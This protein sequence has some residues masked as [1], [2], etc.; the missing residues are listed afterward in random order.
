MTY[1]VLARKW[2][3]QFFSDLIGQEAVSRTLENAIKLGKVPHAILFTGTRGVG[4]T[5]SARILAKALNC[6]KGP[7]ITPCNECSNCTEISAG[8]NVDVLEIDGASNTSVD[9]VRELKETV[10][11]APSKSRHKIYIID[12][13]HMLST[14][15]FNALLKTLEEP[16]PGV[17]FIFA[18]TEPQKIPETIHSRCQRFDFKQVSNLEIEK[19]LLK[20]IQS[21]NFQLGET[22][23]RLISR[24]ALGSVRDAISLLE[25]VIAFSGDPKS[26]VPEDEVAKILGL[27][28][29][30]LIADTLD[31]FVSGNYDKALHSI[32]EVFSKGFDPKTYLEELWEKVRDMMILK[33]TGKNELLH[34]SADEINKMQLWVAAL[35]LE[36][37]ER[38]FA[39]LKSAYLEV[40]RVQFPKYLLEMSFLQ[41]TYRQERIALSSLLSRLEK[42]EQGFKMAPTISKAKQSNESPLERKITPSAEKKTLEFS[43]EM[44]VDAVK[45]KRP[46]LAAILLQTNSHDYDNGMLSLYFNPSS[47]YID[48]AKDADFKAC[49]S[50]ASLKLFGFSLNLKIGVSENS[51]AH[52]RQS[53]MHQ[54]RKNEKEALE[55]PIVKKA[56]SLFQARVEDV[57][58]RT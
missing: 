32:S 4:K 27:T 14:S 31:A 54:D 36:E 58:L 55:D 46:S 7:T 51:E 37:I 3:P 52:S 33:A 12:E 48:R 28:D 57:K 22:A 39:I 8:T 41:I 20:I 42:L 25:Q 34:A 21:E 56:I 45:K 50:E 30:A 35:E 44:L 5:T 29:R 26:G 6:E 11:Y 19:H 13:V 1:V 10:R 43:W 47:F 16:P 2:R 9:D 15:A 23:I 38:W 40:S 17:M 18:T 49:L 53:Q 24:Q